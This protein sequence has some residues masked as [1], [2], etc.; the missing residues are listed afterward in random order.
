MLIII[1][2]TSKYSLLHSLPSIKIIIITC[3]VHHLLFVFNYISYFHFLNFY[4]FLELAREILDVCVCLSICMTFNSLR[5]C[6]Y[7]HLCEIH[8][9]QTVNWSITDVTC[10]LGTCLY[11]LLGISCS[12]C[13]EKRPSSYSRAFLFYPFIVL[14]THAYIHVY[15]TT[16]VCKSVHASRRSCVYERHG[17]GE[18][19]NRLRP[20]SRNLGL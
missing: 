13:P 8:A 18:R 10:Q 11:T 14:F 7:A 20:S 1:Y 2:A 19:T 15:A 9:K 17:R 16:C 5:V 6:T 12:L 3:N 4:S